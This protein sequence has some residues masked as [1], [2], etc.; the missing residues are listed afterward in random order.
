MSAPEDNPADDISEEEFWR[1]LFDAATPAEPEPAHVWDDDGGR[2]PSFEESP[3]EE[4]IGDDPDD[5]VKDEF[6]PLFR[7]LGNSSGG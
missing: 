6:T 3:T 2:P 5:Y 4:I 7:D 1:G